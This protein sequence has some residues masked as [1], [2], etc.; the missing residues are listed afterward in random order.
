MSLQLL[1]FQLWYISN[2]RLVWELVKYLIFVTCWQ[3]N[4]LLWYVMDRNKGVFFL[5]LF[6]FTTLSFE[7]LLLQIK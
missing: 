3:Q 6:L 7:N 5:I 1:Q 2:A 4:Y